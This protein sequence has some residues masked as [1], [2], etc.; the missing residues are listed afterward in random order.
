M[1]TIKEQVKQI[2]MDQLGVTENAV[3]ES[4]SLVKDFDL[5]SLDIVEIAMTI[6]YDFDLKIPEADYDKLTNIDAIV[7]YIDERFAAEE[8][9]KE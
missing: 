8:S 3:L 4:T 7:S 2:L 1:A 9:K 5:S 6:E